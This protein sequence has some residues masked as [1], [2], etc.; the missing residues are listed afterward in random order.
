M[1]HILRRGVGRT[2]DLVQGL[3]AMTRITD[4]CGDLRGESC[5]WLNS[6]GHHLQ[7]RGHMGRTVC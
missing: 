5:G 4:M 7:G 6:S 3:S 2:S 1:R